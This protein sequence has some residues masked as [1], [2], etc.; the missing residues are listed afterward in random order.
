INDA[1]LELLGCPLGGNRDAE[2]RQLWESHLLGRPVW[3]LIPIENLKFRLEDSL[4]HGAKHY[5]PEQSLQVG[6]TAA[7]DGGSLH[8][9]V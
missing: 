2:I 3:S 9:D 8:C 1:A 7:G 4:N 5:V 6:V